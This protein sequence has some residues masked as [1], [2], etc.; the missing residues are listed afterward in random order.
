M[1]SNVFIHLFICLSNH[2]LWIH[3]LLVLISYHNH[4]M[5][6]IGLSP[7]TAPPRLPPGAWL[8]P[9]SAE[10]GPGPRLSPAR[11]PS[12]RLA[13]PESGSVRIRTRRSGEYSWR[14]MARGQQTFW[15]VWGQWEA[16]CWHKQ[17]IGWRIVWEIKMH[18]ASPARVYLTPWITI[19]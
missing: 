7:V 12:L 10:S 4:M 3:L 13:T 16:R 5:L 11:A 1:P 14:K 19:H 15:S 8:C 6:L 17:P 9:M 18:R 2:F